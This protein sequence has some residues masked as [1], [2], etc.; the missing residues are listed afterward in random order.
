[1]GP[2]AHDRRLD[3]MERFVSD[4]VDKGAKIKTGGKEKEKVTF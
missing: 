4:A 3:A 2:L 1:M